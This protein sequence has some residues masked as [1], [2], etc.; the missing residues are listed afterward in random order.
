[1]NISNKHM[2][3]LCTSL[4]KSRLLMG[5]H[6][7]DNSICTNKKFMLEIMDILGLSQIDI[8][9]QRST[10]EDQPENIKIKEDNEN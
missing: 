8:P 3:E 2:K 10:I 1:M 4:T 7:N 5:V 9:A 6:L